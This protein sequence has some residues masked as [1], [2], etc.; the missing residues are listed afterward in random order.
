MDQDFALEWV[1]VPSLLVSE[2]GYRLF[3]TDMEN[4]GKISTA[5]SED[6]LVWSGLEELLAGSDLDEACG[7]Y[8]VDA[9]VVYLDD[10]GF[11]LLAEALDDIKRRLCSASSDDG[12]VW[13]AEEGVRWS[14][15]DQDADQT[16]VPEV[17]RQ[18]DGSWLLYYLGDLGSTLGKGDGVRVAQSWD[19]WEWS[20]L[21]QENVLDRHDTDPFPVHLEGGGVRVYHTHPVNMG[22][23]AYSE[24]GDGI[25]FGE[26][27]YL[28]GLGE[29][30]EP[31]EERWMDPVVLRL[32]DD[33]IVMYMT[34]MILK[35]EEI[36]WCALGR[37]WA[38]D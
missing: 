33:R 23:L 24:T 6:G 21:V 31:A 1:T 2:D 15:T 28:Q 16:S 13:V 38:T 17:L 25:N 36:A 14:G 26:A 19:G 8:L 22:R 37:A 20:P 29:G 5:R 7:E 35:G 30:D 34:R 27:T 18:R 10:G 11:R 4:W 32:P 9:A 12:H 3:A